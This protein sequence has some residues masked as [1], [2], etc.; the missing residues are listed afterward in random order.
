MRR[1]EAGDLVG[2]RA[3]V[4]EDAEIQMAYLQG[5]IACGP[6]ALEE[7]LNAASRSVHRPRMDGIVPIDE[8]AAIL[9]G[10]VRYPIE[11]GGFGDR[12]AAWLNV[13]KDGLLWR[14]RIYPDVE[15]ARQAYAS[16]FLSQLQG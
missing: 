7:A 16:E 14:V 6:G 12:R 13:V 3:L 5:E 2:L 11:G 10:R 15:T 1:Y 8:S 9:H 4:H